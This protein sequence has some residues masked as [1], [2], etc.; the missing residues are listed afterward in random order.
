M[1]AEIADDNNPVFD[2]ALRLINETSRNIFITGRAGTGKTTFLKAV[3]QSCTKQ[4]AVVA[5]TGVAAINARGVTIHSFFQLPFSPFVPAN[6]AGNDSSIGKH[7]LLSR[8]R[9]SADRKK[10][11]QELD[12]LVIDEISMVRCDLL[13]AIDAV[14]RFVRNRTQDP[15]GG[16]QL[17]FIGD[18]YQLPPVV[19]DPVWRIL[20][21]FYA[22]PYFFSSLAVQEAPPLL[23]EFTKIYRQREQAF[24]ELLNEVR[25]NTLGAK[26]FEMLESRYRPSFRPARN[27]GFIVLTTHHQK[28]DHINTAALKKIDGKEFAFEA[29]IEGDFSEKAFPTDQQLKLKVGAQVMFMRNDTEGL[30]RFFNGK[31]GIVKRID[32]DKIFIV[33]EGE[34]DEIEVRRET[35]ENI[36]YT[37]GGTGHE[38]EEEVLGSFVQFPLRLA[39]AITIH[40]SQGLTFEKVVVDAGDAFAPGQ[41]YVA[42]SRCTSLEGLVLQTRISASSMR[43]DER[44]TIY[45][46]HQ[47]IRDLEQEFLVA[48]QDAELAILFSIF[49]FSRIH[50][51]VGHV[52]NILKE[53][54][55]A[56]KTEGSDWIRKLSDEANSLTV[57]AEKFV[58]QIKYLTTSSSGEDNIQKRTRAAAEFF[59]DHLQRMIA[60]LNS[61]PVLTDSPRFAKQ[62]LLLLNELLERRRVMPV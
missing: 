27:E 23:V 34:A 59:R 52:E 55:P 5:P 43:I 32:Q 18:M 56:F 33:S 62:V 60:S 17:V 42:L 16:V 6:N 13:D 47:A 40:K 35:W 3:Q 38:L 4:L 12:I 50:R 1:A 53:Q 11:I 10:V 20:S 21:S 26:S 7:Q 15:F 24:V 58:R 25:H 46:E 36:R 48:K 45:L 28:A 51:M 30:K 14:M 49:D 2:I 44:I 29:T 31:I 8:L 22:S 39:W 9:L 61:P 57:V 37:V 54:T 41:V 19:P